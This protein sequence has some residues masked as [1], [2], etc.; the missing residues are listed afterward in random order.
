M[1]GGPSGFNNAPVT[2]I[3]VIASALFTVVFG[4]QGRSRNLPW[5]Y[6]DI[7]KKLQIW[8]LIVTVFGF[9][10][11]PELV[12]GIYLLYYFRV[13]ERQI[14]SNKY[15]VFILFSVITS[16]LLEVLAQWLLKDPSLNILTSGPYGLIF[17]SF[18]PFFFDIPVSTRFRV[19]RFN[20][21]DKTFIYLAGL[22]L[23]LSSWRRSMLPGICGILAGSL[24]RL[25]VFRVRR[26]KFPEVIASFFSRLSWP[27]TGTTSP[28]RSSRNVL[29]SAPTY[30]SRRAEAN[31]PA[32]LSTLL[33]P[34]EESI[35]TLV[36]MGFDRNSARQALIHARND[37]N[38]AT[39]I[40]L[41]S[42]GH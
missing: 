34:P 32:L 10:S 11:T 27:S 33:E 12:F 40:L 5:S 15:T 14:G 7:F 6:Q 42:Q 30:A 13:F 38:A 3:I 25:N 1:N 24:Y 21:S 23:F 35:G 8:K 9:S 37:I 39:N 22:Q 28:T 17:A 18:V 31:A 29:G 19:F 4:I 20:F 2:R 41:E 36:S 16:L 26:V